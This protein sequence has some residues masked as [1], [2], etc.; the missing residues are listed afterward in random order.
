MA[1]NHIYV[2]VVNPAPE[3][4]EFSNI[5]RDCINA[6]HGRGWLETYGSYPAI[7]EERTEEVRYKNAIAESFV[8]SI[9]VPDIFYESL[10]LSDISHC[11]EQAAIQMG[12]D[13][14]EFAESGKYKYDPFNWM[15][16]A[17]D[18]ERLGLR[19]EDYFLDI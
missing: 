19:P 13:H 11:V 1:E 16:A 8:Y 18:M 17:N 7:I 6:L 14:A 2:E 12:M 4:P 9:Q 5:I 10:E 3:S 15:V